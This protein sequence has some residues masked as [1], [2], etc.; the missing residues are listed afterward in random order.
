V[1]GDPKTT[2]GLPVVFAIE[3]GIVRM[4][5][6]SRSAV[7]AAIEKMPADEFRT[8][9]LSQHEI[10]VSAHSV[11]RLDRYYHQRMGKYLSQNDVELGLR[12]DD[13][14]EKHPRGVL[15][16]KIGAPFRNPRPP[17]GGEAATGSGER[18]DA[19]G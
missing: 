7:E 3:E 14:R 6:V 4:S 19:Q 18:S 16:R 13:K 9:D 15:W 17:A 12:C 8:K 5:D 10:M 1:W 11:F 2:R